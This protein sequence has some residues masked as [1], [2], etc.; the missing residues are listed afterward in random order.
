MKKRAE[1]LKPGPYISSNK[2]DYGQRKQH[3]TSIP[4]RYLFCQPHAKTYLQRFTGRLLLRCIH[5]RRRWPCRRTDFLRVHVPQ[6]QFTSPRNTSKQSRRRIQG[7][8]DKKVRP[9]HRHSRCR[10][11][12]DLRK[13]QRNQ[14]PLSRY[15]HRPAYTFRPRGLPPIGKRRPQW[16]RLRF[17]LAGK[18]RFII[19]YHQVARR[20]NE[21]RRR[22][23]VGRTDYHVGR[24][25]GTVLLLDTAPSI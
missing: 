14:A 7:I 3:Q 18:Y 24:R 9:H 23:Q 10:T 13:G 17:Q 16:Y 2:E 1:L 21:Y 4:E 15:S 8:I 22:Y 25:L 12:S 20:R 11:Q 5:S 19:G 6:P